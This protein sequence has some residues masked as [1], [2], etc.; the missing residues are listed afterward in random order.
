MASKSST[1]G[2]I[3]YDSNTKKYSLPKEH[4]LALAD[5]NS[6]V[7]AIGSFQTLKSLFKDEE[8]ILKA[9]KTGRGLKWGDHDANL[10]EG[11]ER[12]FGANYKANII[13]SWIPSINGGRVEEKLKQ[14]GARVADVGC[15]HGIST[16]LMAKA[17]PNSKFIGFDNHLAS[18]K[19]AKRMLKKKV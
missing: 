13:Q 19:R 5:D 18:I 14:G 7:Y 6:P 16:I 17:Y 3:L 1:S 10:F 15:G 9:F 4:A 11:T 2:Y 8:K 12:F